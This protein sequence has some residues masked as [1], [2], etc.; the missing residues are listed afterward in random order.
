MIHFGSRLADAVGIEDII[1]ILCGRRRTGSIVAPNSILARG[2]T[3]G[4]GYFARGL[5]GLLARNESESEDAR[6]YMSETIHVMEF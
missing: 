3:E 6:E 2:E 1:N 5:L 4:S